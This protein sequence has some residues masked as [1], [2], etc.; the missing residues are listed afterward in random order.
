M[1]SSHCVRYPE[2]ILEFKEFGNDA[3]KA[4]DV[5]VAMEQCVEYTTVARCVCVDQYELC[6]I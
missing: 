2:A 1:L 3:F 4:G 6:V 5:E